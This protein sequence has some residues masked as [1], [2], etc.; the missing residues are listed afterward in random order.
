VTPLFFPVLPDSYIKFEDFE[1]PLHSSMLLPH[2]FGI[3]P[4]SSIVQPNTYNMELS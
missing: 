3:K 4:E 1:E 2:G